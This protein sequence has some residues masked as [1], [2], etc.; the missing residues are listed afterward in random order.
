[1]QK[2]SSKT[3]APK[4]AANA[5]SSFQDLIIAY[6]KQT[7]SSCKALDGFLAFCVLTGVI[8]AAYCLL[9]SSFPFN[10]F[11]GVFAASVGSFV[12]AGKR[13]WD[14]FQSSLYIFFNFSKLTPEMEQDSRKGAKSEGSY[15]LV[16][17]VPGV[18][19]DFTH[20][21]CQFHWL[22]DANN[23][24]KAHRKKLSGHVPLVSFLKMPPPAS[25]VF[26]PLDPAPL[27]ILVGRE[28]ELN[29]EARDR[30]IDAI[31][32]YCTETQPTLQYASSNS[33]GSLADLRASQASLSNQNN[34][35]NANDP[36]NLLSSLLKIN[37]ED[38]LVIV[39]VFS[40]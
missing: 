30:L 5:S 14:A 32:R 37:Y 16:N 35:N 31:T 26:N 12:F 39:S 17:R 28:T 24:R 18:Y 36:R 19:A 1:M 27:A 40:C 6:H 3:S 4:P 9:V 23:K 7:S 10:A 22:R 21:C 34:S 13:S 29:W 15:S 20:V 38:I 11:L 25:S 2:S 8:Q 33:F